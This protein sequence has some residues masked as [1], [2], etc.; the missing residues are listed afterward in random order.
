MATYD[1][2]H[3]T[4][5]EQVQVLVGRGMAVTNQADAEA[6]LGTVGYYRLS[7]Y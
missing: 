7:G 5:S 2:P 3:L 4:L 1:K 6:L